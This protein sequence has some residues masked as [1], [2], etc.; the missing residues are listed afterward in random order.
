[1]SRSEI[2]DGRWEMEDG[3]WKMGDGGSEVGGR[4][5]AILADGLDG[6]AFLGFFA[7]GFFFRVLGLFIDERVTAV[8]VSLKIVRR[9]LAAKVAINAGV[10]HVILAFGVFR[11]LVCNVSH[12]NTSIRPTVC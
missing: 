11:I 4:S 12:K 8:I 9:G 2:E 3:R 7:A 5:G 6:A 1:M 10:I